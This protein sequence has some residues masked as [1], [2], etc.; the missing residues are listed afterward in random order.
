[1]I[2]R[3][4]QRGLYQGARRKIN[5]MK[6]LSGGTWVACPVGLTQE[7]VDE[8]LEHPW[9]VIGPIGVHECDS[10]EEAYC[11]AKRLAE[12]WGGNYILKRGSLAERAAR[13]EDHHYEM[14]AASHE[15][16]AG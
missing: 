6:A 5:D 16:M 15:A 10:K 2:R 8:C 1:V 4:R 9:E 11:L 13:R 12:S 3:G 7:D 14:M